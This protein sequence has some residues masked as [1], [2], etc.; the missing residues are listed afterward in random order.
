MGTLDPQPAS[1]TAPEEET[2]PQEFIQTIDGRLE[3]E[4][5]LVMVVDDD[6]QLRRLLCKEIHRL[7]PQVLTVEAGNG[8]QA[9]ERLA[10]IR[11]SFKVEP[12]LMLLDLKMPVMD[13]WEVIEALRKEYEEEGETQG[14]PI[15]VLSSTTGDKRSGFTR[16][17]VHGRR[18]K[19]TPLVSGAKDKCLDPLRYDVQDRSGL[20]AWIRHFLHKD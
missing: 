2:S 12:L 9:L 4:T 11:D 10:D 6:E 14:I 1:P 20:I 7:A 17:S 5:H 13:G 19:Y 16:Q 8:Q 15:I 18:A 3:V